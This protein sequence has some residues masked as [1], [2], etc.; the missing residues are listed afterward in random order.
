MGNIHGNI[1]WVQICNWSTSFLAIW[2]EVRS[3]DECD[4]FLFWLLRRSVWAIYYLDLKQQS[5]LKVLKL[6][7]N[8]GSQEIK[9]VNV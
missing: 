8:L 1:W 7:V 3:F 2:P 9:V 5:F 4:F 6:N